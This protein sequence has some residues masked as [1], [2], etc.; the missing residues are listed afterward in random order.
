M[1]AA[2]QGR[3]R[4]VLDAGCGDG[5][6]TEWLHRGLHRGL[7][8]ARISGVDVSAD[9]LARARGRVPAAELGVAD[10]H[11]LPYGEGEFDLVV[12]TQVLEHV[13]DPRAALDELRRVSR[14]RV[15]VTVPHEP[16]FRAGNLLRGRHLGRL[17]STPGHRWTWTRAGFR[18]LVG[19]D[20]RRL[21]LFPWQGAVLYT[22]SSSRTS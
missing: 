4:T 9:A 6:V 1:D 13:A 14:A 17:G 21:S 12:C 2:A 11:D 20:A 5:H 7:P 22:M 18:R 15:L 8:G 3:P 16:W 19:A 10:V